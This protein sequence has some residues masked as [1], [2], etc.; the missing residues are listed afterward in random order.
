MSQGNLEGPIHNICY[1]GLEEKVYLT[2]LE[3]QLHGTDGII[4]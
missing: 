4:K 1:G 2:I 3:M